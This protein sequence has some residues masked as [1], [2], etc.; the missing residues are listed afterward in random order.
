MNFNIF[1][2]SPPNIASL[3]Q[4]NDTLSSQGFEYIIFENE[5]IPI[6]NYKKKSLKNKLQESRKVWGLPLK[7]IN[8]ICKNT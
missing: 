2:G 4:K 1:Q 8:F 5:N 3:W 6:F 7:Y